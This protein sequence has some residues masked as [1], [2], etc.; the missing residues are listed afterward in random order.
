[1]RQV[2]RNRKSGMTLVEVLIAVV[3]AGVCASVVY[4]GGFYSY[5]VMMR[6]RARLEAQGI[7]FDKTWELFNMSYGDLP[8]TSTLGSEATDEDSVFSTQGRVQWAVM[9]EVNPPLN[10]IDYWMIQ[11]QVWAP[12]DSV[13]FSVMN[14][15]GSVAAEFPHPLAEYTV[16][17]YRGERGSTE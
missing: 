8:S 16:L 1:M 5:K 12:T 10:R 17:R 14:S 7:A 13:L 4:N 2:H 11:V 15:D 6:S 9:P 3:L